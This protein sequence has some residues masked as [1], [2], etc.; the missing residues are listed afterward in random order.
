[1]TLLA[2]GDVSFGQLRG[3][4][5][6]RTPERDDFA[7][8]RSL[9]ER[10]DLRFV[11]LESQLSDQQ[12][13]TVS[14]HNPLVFT[15]PPS[16][17]DA[18]ARGR[19]DVVSLGN[20]HAWDYGREAFFETL[21]ALERVQVRWVGAGRTESETLAPL[22]VQ[23][24]GMGIAFVAATAIWNQGPLGQHPAKPHVLE[25]TEASLRAAVGRARA[26]AGVEV[27]VVS[28]HAGDEYEDTPREGVRR[29][30]RSA[31][32]AGAD[33]VLGHHPHVIQ[34]VEWVDGT[35][36][37]FSLGN[38]LMRMVTGKPWTEYGLLARVELQRGARPKAEACPVRIHGLDAIPLGADP[39]RA[40]VEPFF[41]ARFERLLAAGAAV[42]PS[43]RVRLGPFDEHGCARL[44]PGSE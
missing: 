14:P 18:L 9:L 35:P 22:V 11:N 1:V 7:P 42:D 36:V 34:R 19:I 13:E 40:S 39:Q 31:V 3:Q 38:L 23:R 29:L 6:L 15:G 44:Y 4:E 43:S 12:G 10:A 25:A 27:V 32:S 28:V 37:F 33:V 16:G 17:A 30:L 8:L 41:R 26:T 2:G 20:N 24:G 21:D 5:L